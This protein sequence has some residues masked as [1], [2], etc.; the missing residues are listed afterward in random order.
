M[1][2]HRALACTLIRML[3][4]ICRATKAPT[5]IKIGYSDG[6]KIVSVGYITTTKTFSGGRRN[7]VVDAA[8]RAYS[9][10]RSMTIAN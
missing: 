6:Q 10:A 8:A 5:T 1:F 3:C 2:E 7:R 4:R 9:I